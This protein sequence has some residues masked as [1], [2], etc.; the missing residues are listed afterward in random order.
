MQAAVRRMLPHA[1]AFCLAATGCDR[2]SPPAGSRQDHAPPLRTHG[3]SASTVSVPVDGNLCQRT[4]SF[5]AH[6]RS[7]CACAGE[8]G[9]ELC[10][11]GGC[12]CAANG[13]QAASDI[14]YGHPMFAGRVM[15]VHRGIVAYASTG[16]VDLYALRRGC[17]WSPAWPVVIP[18]PAEQIAIGDGGQL[19]WVTAALESRVIEVPSRATVATFSHPDAVRVAVGAR[20]VARFAVATRDR[21]EVYSGAKWETG[22]NAPGVQAVCLSPNGGRLAVCYERECVMFD[23]DGDAPRFLARWGANVASSACVSTDDGLLAVP[24]PGVLTPRREVPL[25]PAGAVALAWGGEPA[26][27]WTASSE[28]IRGAGL[29]G[30]PPWRPDPDGRVDLISVGW[31][32]EVI[33]VSSAGRIHARTP[34]GRECPTQDLR[35]SVLLDARVTSAGIVMVDAQGD[36]WRVQQ[37]SVVP[38]LKVGRVR[39][40]GFF[41]AIAV[42]AQGDIRVQTD[43]EDVFL[44]PGGERVPVPR[45]R[46]RVLREKRLCVTGDQACVV[47]GEAILFGR[48]GSVHGH[49]WLFRDGQWGYLSPRGASGTVSGL[50]RV[51]EVRDGQPRVLRRSVADDLLVWKAVAD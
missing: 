8:E 34:D 51:V 23:L 19:L 38:A 21:V 4:W 6:D 37:G 31:Q 16:R 48:N 49:L 27:F 36:V 1:L 45:E 13:R 46:A 28:G 39:T 41:A 50:G 5:S 3:S 29:D 7:V 12:V 30:G 42:E 9:L 35:L 47:D 15:A 26:R 14:V 10:D 25:G 32:S 44:K 11:F 2:R 22:L 17:E 24:G 40:R 43:M 18:T 20:D 33:A